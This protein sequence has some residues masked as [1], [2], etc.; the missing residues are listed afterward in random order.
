MNLWKRQK[1]ILA[2]FGIF[3]GLMYL[4]TLISRAVYANGLPRVETKKP[5]RMAIDH[6]VEAGGMVQQ[7]QEYA[8]Y[9]PSGLRVRTVHAHVGDRVTSETLL[10]ELDLEELEE[11]IRRKQN[12]V[13]KLELQLQASEEELAHAEAQRQTELA[14]AREDYER[15]DREGRADMEDAE[16]GR[17]MMEAARSRESAMQ[18]AWRRLEDAETQPVTDSSQEL[19]RL[20]LSEAEEELEKYEQ[21][22]E[23]DGKVYLETEGI[24][25]GLSVSAGEY[26][27][28]GA[29]V[30]Y[31]DMESSLRFHATLTKEQKNYV[32]QGSPAKLE[33]D[34]G[35]CEVTVDYLEQNE[36][37]P[38][39]YKAEIILPEGIGRIG[40]SGNL[41]VEARSE[42]FEVCVPMEALHTDSNQRSYVFILREQEGILGTELVAEQVYVKVLDQNDS[43]AAI[44]P[45]SIDR[46]T[47]V[48]VDA[49]EKLEDRTAVRYESFKM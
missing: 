36:A 45:G 7:G 20:E 33:L 31:A 32:D 39:S 35:S 1:K 25:T 34:G 37:E 14:R 13:R 3:L 24:I 42:T 49:S 4:C 47:E 23:Q 41:Q 40:Q 15:A 46:E 9:L 30:L 19:I 28:D 5:Q 2:A 8:L 18:E 11:L 6:R 17:E 44:E 38:E 21:V 12:A 16:E 10:F 27:P 48:I 29:A 43:H 26:V 22:Q